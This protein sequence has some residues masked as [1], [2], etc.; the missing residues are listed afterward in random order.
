MY[1]NIKMSSGLLVHTHTHIHLHYRDISPDYEPLS[2]TLSSPGPSVSERGGLNS[3]PRCPSII[4]QVV[5][6]I[7]SPPLTPAPAPIIVTPVP[8]PPIKQQ[9]P[10]QKSISVI[11]NKSP[12]SKVI[13][14]KIQAL[15]RRDINHINQQLLKAG[16]GSLMAKKEVKIIKMASATQFT[17]VTA[18]ATTTTTTPAGNLSSITGNKKVTIRLPDGQ[19][20]V[21]SPPGTFIINK[22]NGNMPG[23]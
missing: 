10:Q 18:T 5:T 7:T 3:P 13:I 9:Q 22:N 19:K 8:S 4:Q 17:N 23:K 12:S 11:L 21:K 1:T 16:K 6:P 14:D 20:L 2:P 15:P